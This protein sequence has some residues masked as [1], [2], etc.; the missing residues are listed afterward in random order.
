MLDGSKNRI[1]MQNGPRTPMGE[2]LRRYWMPIAA[3]SEFEKIRAKAV[4][5]LGEDLSLY[6]DLNGR[7]GLVDRRW[8]RDLLSRN[9]R[10]SALRSSRDP[11]NQVRQKESWVALTERSG[12]N[13][14]WTSRPDRSPER[15][16][17][18]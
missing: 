8:F 4:R 15:Q 1:L 17:A 3:V 10:P 2:L 7:Y 9:R 12:V 13:W 5:L 18:L 6:L 11:V 16:L 14:A